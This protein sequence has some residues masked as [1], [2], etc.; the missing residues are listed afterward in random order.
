LG[1]EAQKYIKKGSLV[2]DSTINKLVIKELSENFV[3]KN[4]LL[5]GYPRNLSQSFELWSHED[6]RPNS[7]LNLVVPDEEIIERIR[8]RWIHPGSSR[9][10]HMIYNPP[11]KAGFDDVTGEALVQREDDKEEVVRG[12]LVAFHKENLQIV[13]FFR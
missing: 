8:H 1:A 5:D 2:P 3:G 12:R 11:K 7:V 10:Y 9:I 13:D 6:V 4:Y